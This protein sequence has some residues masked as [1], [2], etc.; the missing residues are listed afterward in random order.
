MRCVYIIF[1]RRSLCDV[2]ARYTN[3]KPFSGELNTI[4]IRIRRSCILAFVNINSEL[5]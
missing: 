4:Y 2:F 1:S 3:L 5:E